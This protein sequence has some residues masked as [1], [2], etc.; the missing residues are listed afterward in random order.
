M[1]NY[2]MVA[3]MENKGLPGKNVPISP[4]KGIICRDEVKPFLA[5]AILNQRRGPKYGNLK[6]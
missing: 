4:S 1:R 2:I 3:W 6:G 5:Q